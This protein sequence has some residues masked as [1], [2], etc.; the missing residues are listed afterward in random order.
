[1]ISYFRYA[2]LLFAALL[3]TDAYCDGWTF[4]DARSELGRFSLGFASGLVGHELGHY[5]VATSK[6]YNVGHDGLSI[7]YPGAVFTPAD[8]LQVASAGFQVQWVMAEFALR[9][10]H[11]KELKEPPGN[12]GAG[13]VCAHL[14]ITSAYLV[15]LKDHPQGDI[16]GMAQATGY[17]NDRIAM[18][19]AIPGALDAWRLFGKQVPEWVPQLSVLSKG[20]GMAWIWTY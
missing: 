13:V 18:A 20:V 2:S 10:S 9:D 19:L 5:V 11:G 12:F 3:S 7:V 17:S 1:L 6:G 14:A 15:Y 8:H 16:V 4:D